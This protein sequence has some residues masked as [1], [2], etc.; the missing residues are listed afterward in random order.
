MNKQS[1]L[2]I[3]AVSVFIASCGNK[4]DKSAQAGG[5]PQVKEYKTI[6]GSGDPKGIVKLYQ[7]KVLL[8]ERLLQRTD[9]ELELYK[10]KFGVL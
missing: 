3:L 9:R 5:A 1:L 2:S 7:D 6:T 4:N 8:L 10:K